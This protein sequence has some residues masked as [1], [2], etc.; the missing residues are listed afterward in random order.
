MSAVITRVGRT[1]TFA[2]YACLVFTAACVASVSYQ[3]AV[4]VPAPSS[5]VSWPV[6]ERNLTDALSR[7]SGS[8]QDGRATPRGLELPRDSSGR[9]WVVPFVD[10]KPLLEDV[11]RFVRGGWSAL[12]PKTDRAR[13]LSETEITSANPVAL[14]SAYHAV[15]FRSKT[16]AEAFLQ[17]WHDA[18]LA[19]RALPDPE[20]E[21]ARQAALWRARNPKPPLSAAANRHRL[22]AEDATRARDYAR[23]IQE[24]EAALETD[25]TWP[26]G[27]FNLALLYEAI[28]DWDE[29]V[30]YMRRFLLLEPDSREA[31]A[32]REKIVLWDD[33]ARR[34]PATPE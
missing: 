21:F 25:P 22:L 33:R 30:R 32:A 5:V 11:G 28:E 26:S 17:A 31:A 34:A 15:W 19:R 1:R 20:S 2:P 16:D 9:S 27:N 23:A 13:A 29:A 6:A 4:F 24:F 8:N 3:R 18:V 10:A 12:I 14:S 7:A